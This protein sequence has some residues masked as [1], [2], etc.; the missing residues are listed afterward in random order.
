MS[1][2]LQ[3]WC[4]KLKR[5]VTEGQPMAR[6]IRLMT[7]GEG[8]V[9]ETWEL[10]SEL[11]PAQ[12]ASDAES[13]ISAL[14]PELPKRRMQLVFTAED[15]AGA[16]V[17]NKVRGVT[18]QNPNAQDLGTQ[19]GAKALADAI[20]SV[21]KTMDATLETAR[22]I[23]AFQLD[24]LEKAHGHV[25]DAHEVLMAIKKVE[26]ESEEQQSAASKIMMEQVQQATPLLMQLLQHWATSPPKAKTTGGIAAVATAAATNGAS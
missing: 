26:L 18:G 20:A 8:T 1:Q 9:W 24:Q 2:E 13:V 5:E 7:A 4:E 23:M 12:W 22:K 14:L 3:I 17:A 21:A 6:R 16:T 10:T 15:A 19:N 11:E 25:A